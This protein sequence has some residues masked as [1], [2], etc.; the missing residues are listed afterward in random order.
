MYQGKFEGKF[1]M[2]D[3]YIDGKA[4]IHDFVGVG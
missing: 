1:G 4:Y 3:L 2:W